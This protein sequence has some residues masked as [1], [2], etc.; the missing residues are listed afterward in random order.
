MSGLWAQLTALDLKSVALDHTLASCCFFISS[1]CCLWRWNPEVPRRPHWHPVTST[2]YDSAQS[3]F[4]PS[5]WVSLRNL[6]Q[7]PF[8]QCFSY[9]TAKSSFRLI[10]S[11]SSA[12][13]KQSLSGSVGSL[14]TSELISSKSLWRSA[15]G[16][17]N[18]RWKENLGLELICLLKENE[19]LGSG[20]WWMLFLT[21]T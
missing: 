4:S 5:V 11:C 17:K 9:I 14:Q 3:L 2:V 13:I 16:F 15:A 6:H 19:C 18:Y 7:F 1:S 8:L 12:Y 20:R 21:P 10:G